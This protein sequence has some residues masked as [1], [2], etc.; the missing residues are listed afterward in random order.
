MVHGLQ[1]LSDCS[2]SSVKLQFVTAGLQYRRLQGLGWLDDVRTIVYVNAEGLARH[3]GHGEGRLL[4]L[5]G[6]L[7]SKSTKAFC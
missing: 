4:G 6:I 7:T 3:Y 2:D 1:R 5:L